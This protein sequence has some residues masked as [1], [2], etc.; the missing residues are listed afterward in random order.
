MK[1]LLIFFGTFTLT[2]F[3][4]SASYAASLSKPS[5]ANITSYANTYGEYSKSD[6]KKLKKYDIV[7]IDNVD[8]PDENF[9]KKLKKEGVIVLAY[10]NIGEVEE[11]RG[12]WK[13]LD[14]SII[15]S[16]DPDYDNNYY[17][18]VNNQKWHDA[19]LKQE[20]P[21][22]LASGPYDG[23]MLDMVCTPDLL[24]DSSLKQGII[25]LVK[26][27]HQAYP[28][29]LLVP[30]QGFGVLKDIYQYIDAFKYEG[31]CAHYDFDKKKYVYENDTDEQAVLFDVLK[32]KPMLVLVL[33][34]VKTH[35]KNNQMAKKCFNK[36]VK[37][38]KITGIPFIWYANSVEQDLPTWNF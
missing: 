8:T 6:L 13:I 17:A 32:K 25:N 30:N 1:K 29:L 10:L 19:I 20:I 26:E 33:D 38:Q 36:A 22:I 3:I 27:I 12:Y 9:V 23:L 14:K 37:F 16:A 24:K 15:I 34:H 31:M 11:A 7:V 2:L 4:V 18:D 5:L 21:T 28:N 35:P